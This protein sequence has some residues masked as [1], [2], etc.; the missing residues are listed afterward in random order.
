MTDVKN[1]F[2]EAQKLLI[3]LDGGKE[4]KCFANI[5]F[6]WHKIFDNDIALLTT[7]GKLKNSKS[8][9][10]LEVKVLNNAVGTE[11]YYRKN[12]ILSRI[13][14]L[15]GQDIVRDI[16]LSVRTEGFKKK[17][18]VCNVIEDNRYTDQIKVQGLKNSLNS[19]YSAIKNHE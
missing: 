1:L 12:E 13:R 3:S 11:L 4:I 17:K 8:G 9:K 10:V 14:D 15:L 19:L 5:L 16:V 18:E 2:K 6:N 7:P